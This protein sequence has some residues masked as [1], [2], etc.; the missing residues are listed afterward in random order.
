M[1]RLRLDDAAYFLHT[2]QEDVPKGVI[3]LSPSIRQGDLWEG[4]PWTRAVVGCGIS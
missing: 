4:I 2:G 3:Y 1:E